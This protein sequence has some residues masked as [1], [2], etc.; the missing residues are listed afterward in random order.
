[1][2]ILKTTS[3]YGILLAFIAL[4]CTALSTGI[5]F[6][7]KNKIDSEIE[8]QQ[9]Q[10]LTEVIPQ[11]YYD[12]DLLSSCSDSTIET[13]KTENINKICTAKKNGKITAYAFETIA[14]D[15]YSG[16]I[17]LLIG[18]SPVGEVLGVR[19]VEHQ[20]TPGLGDKIDLRISDWILSFTNK[21]ITPNDQSEWAVKK[22]GGKFDQFAGATITPRAVVNQV[23]NSS[24]AMLKHIQEKELNRSTLEK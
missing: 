17:R 9:Q 7:T 1:M 4:I 5:Y 23:K 19:V 14:P 22:D 3:Y 12:N 13:I 8:K 20:E 18:L 15:G 16:N 24:L 10:R 21:I 6:L 11:K 2:Q